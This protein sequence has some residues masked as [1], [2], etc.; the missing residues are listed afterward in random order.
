MC[1]PPEISVKA[2]EETRNL[3]PKKSSTICNINCL[4]TELSGK[5][6]SPTLWSI[7]SMLKATLSVR[8]VACQTL[9]VRDDVDLGNYR[10]VISFRKKQ[11]VG[12]VTKKSRIF[13]QRDIE[14][15]LREA[16]DE[17]YLMIKES[18]MLR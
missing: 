4:W 12:H 11:S 7:Y 13:T 3:L 5:C 9:S 8:D 15:F 10:K 1:I 18:A 16:P 2:N 14:K 6:K 17:I